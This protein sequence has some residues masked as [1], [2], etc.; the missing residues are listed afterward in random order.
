MCGG[1]VEDD[2][3]R[4]GQEQAGDREALAFAAG[5][6]VAALPHH[7][8]QAVGQRG[9]QL[10]EP[11]AVQGVDQ[12][13]VGGVRGGVAQVGRDRVVEQVPVLG[14]DA[15]R[16]AHGRERQVA[17]VDPAQ[18][19]GAARR[20]RR[21]AGRASRSSTCPHPEGPTSASSRPG[22][23][24]QVDAV[25]HLLAAALVEHGDLLQRGQRHLVGAGVG[26]PDVAQ[27]HADRPVGQGA[28]VRPLGDHRREVEHL[29]D[30]L[31]RHQR[32]HDVD[33]GVRERGHRRVEPGEQQR[34][35]DD[36]ARLDPPGDREPPAESV[37]QRLGQRR[38]QRQRGDEHPRRPSRC[39]LRCRGSARRGRR[40]RR[41]RRP[42]GR[43]ASP[44]WR[45][46]PRSARSSG[47]TAPR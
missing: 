3:P 18:L 36:G 27:A 11:G 12:L 20:R 44:A 1:L 47:W 32:G 6:P 41:S 15:D 38:H 5:E 4:P 31:E 46:A 14:D 21:A 7:R 34:Q 25:Q 43:T 30:A 40:T 10:A 8:V 24:S 19:D 26:E 29:E 23:T 2:H 16:A 28:G 22:A 17:H 13:G 35:G 9:E 39:A 42:A 33:A 45:R 37:D